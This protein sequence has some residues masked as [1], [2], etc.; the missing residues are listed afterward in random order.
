MSSEVVQIPVAL[1]VVIGFFAMLVIVGFSI[2]L[3]TFLGAGKRDAAVRRRRTNPDAKD[4][5]DPNF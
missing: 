4:P 3:F 1:L 2:A 5:L